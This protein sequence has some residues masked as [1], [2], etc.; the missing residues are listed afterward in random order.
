[1]QQRRFGSFREASQF[2]RELAV[3]HRCSVEITR[4]GDHF[5]VPDLTNSSPPNSP[6]VGVRSVHNG[7]TR[8][9]PWERQL[10]IQRKREEEEAA[11]RLVETRRHEINKK[12]FEERKPYLLERE[13]AYR[14]MDD[15]AIENA[16]ATRDEAGLA[17]DEVEMLRDLVRERKGIKPTP[18]H[19]Q[20]CRSCGQV[21]DN[22]TCTRSWF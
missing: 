22:C 11:Q 10:A 17:L 12:R 7:A 18:G 6:V 19:V 20:V 2:A 13:R 14:S 21:G 9:D 5:L 1:M 8:E 4:D 15:A 3:S 16:W